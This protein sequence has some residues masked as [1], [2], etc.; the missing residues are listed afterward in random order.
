VCHWQ[1]YITRWN[2]GHNDLTMKYYLAKFLRFVP[3]IAGV[4]HISA[5]DNF[6]IIKV[7]TDEALTELQSHPDNIPLLEI[8][9]IEAT[10]AYK[11]YG[12]TRGYRKV[13]SD[14]AG[15]EPDED[16]L[17]KGQRK[18]K[19]YLSDDLKPHVVSIMKKA[20]KFHIAQEMCDRKLLDHKCYDKSLHDSLLAQADGFT[21]IEQIV[22][23]RESLLG[24]EMCKDRAVKLGRWDQE[25]DNRI[26]RVNFG[27]QF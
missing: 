19:V 4:E 9:E 8:A 22:D 23:A 17:A 1:R 6:N 26:D 12:E 27:I 25:K 10:E 2:N 11:F 13:Y 24:I 21:T 15:L 14:Y 20:F 7:S 3:Q 16:E 5:V 18:T